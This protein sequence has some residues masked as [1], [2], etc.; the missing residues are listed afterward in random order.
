MCVVE[1]YVLIEIRINVHLE[2]KYTIYIYIVLGH[3]IYMI[4]CLNLSDIFVLYSHELNNNHL[5]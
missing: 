3:M 5:Y 2:K 4:F 1:V